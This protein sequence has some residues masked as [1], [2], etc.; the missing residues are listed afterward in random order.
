V[1]GAGSGPWVFDGWAG[2][3]PEV[4]VEAIDLHDGLDVGR[5]SMDDYAATVVAAAEQLTPP[6]ALLG[7]SSGGLA[8]LMAAAR[9]RP[10]CVVLVESSTPVEVQGLNP[11]AEIV[12]G[13]FDPEEVYGRFPAGIRARAESLRA[14]GERKRGLS[15]PTLACR[16][17]VV[18]GRD[19][20]DERGRRLAAQYGSA[21]LAFPELDHWQLVLDPRVRE[22]IAAWLRWAV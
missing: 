19:F 6:V 4:A 5:A 11:D 7:W 16:S 12:D 3:F 10:S 17:L 14:R 13:V 8:A 9:A 22:S 20:A 15:V 2:A 21:E 1:H 18:Y